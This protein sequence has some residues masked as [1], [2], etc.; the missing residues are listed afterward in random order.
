MV[1]KP[2]NTSATRMEGTERRMEVESSRPALLSLLASKHL[3]AL[4]VISNPDTLGQG[5]RYAGISH[6]L[7]MLPA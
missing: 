4:T 5:C 7:L 1:S 6:E 2:Q 3:R